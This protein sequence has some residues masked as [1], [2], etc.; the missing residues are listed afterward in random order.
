MTSNG[1][2]TDHCVAIEKNRNLIENMVSDY[3][4]KIV[5]KL[6]LIIMKDF[7]NIP[8][9]PLMRCQSFLYID[10]KKKLLSSKTHFVQ[11]VFKNHVGI[12]K[13]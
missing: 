11:H 3:H 12:S 5:H 9:V 4:Y 2:S 8:V 1:V 6:K 7:T 10:V 13:K